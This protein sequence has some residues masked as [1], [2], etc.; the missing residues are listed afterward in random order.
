MENH[1]MADRST[2]CR[3]YSGLIPTLMTIVLTVVSCV[4]TTPSTPAPRPTPTISESEA[5]EAQSDGLTAYEEEG[6]FICHFEQDDI[7]IWQG[8]TQATETIV[9]EGETPPEGYLNVSG[10]HAKYTDRWIKPA[11]GFVL[12]EDQVKLGATSGKW[13]NTTENTRI[14]TTDIPHDWSE[15][16]FLSFW[17]YSAVENDAAIEIVAYSESEDTAEDDYYKKEI[18]IDW[19]GW[20]LFEIPLHEFGVVR[21]PVGWDKIDYIKIAATGWGHDPN[22][23]TELYFDGMK[24]SNQ[25]V[26]PLMAIELPQDLTHPYLLLNEAEIVEIKDKIEKHPW[27]RE[28]YVSLAANAD[29][30]AS[31]SIQLPDTGGGFYHAEDPTDYAITQEHYDH[32]NA[33]RDLALM[34]HLTGDEKYGQKAKEILMAYVD[35][36]LTYEI[37]DKEGRTGEQA[38]AGGRATPQAINETAW[39]VP[40]AWAYDL[41]YNDLAP[42]ERESIENKILRPAAELIM[43]N[44]EGRHNHQTWHNSGVG[45]VGFVLGDKELVWHALYKDDSGYFYQMEKSITEDGMWYEGSMHYQFYVLRA[46]FPLM[47]AAY[48][49]GIDLYQEPG[50]KGLFDFM[51][52]YADASMRLPTLH[53]G[54]VV[55]LPESDRA[56]YYEVAYRRLGDPRYIPVLQASTR[57]DRYALLYGVS[58]LPEPEWP[59]WESRSFASSHLAVLRSGYGMHSKQVVVNYMGYEGGHSHPDQ[60]GLVLYGLGL[61]LAPDAG[62]VKYRVPAHLEWFK[63]SIAH[64]VIVVDG[65]SQ[66]QASPG[67]LESFVGTPNLQVARVSSEEAYLGV[68]LERT[69]ILNDDYLIDIFQAD[70]ADEHTYD[71]V[72]HNIGRFTTDDLEFQPASAPGDENGYEYL[73]DV[74]SVQSDGD[75]QA[76]WIVAPDRRVRMGLFGAPGAEYF[77]ARGLIAAET[78]DEIAD[79]KVPL[80]IARRHITSTKFVSII[81]PYSDVPPITEMSTA[82]FTGV[83]GEVLSPDEAISLHIERGALTDVILIADAAGQ[84][85]YD[86]Y[87]FDGRMGWICFEGDDLEW[88]YLGMGTTFAGDGWSLLVESMAAASSAE[89]LGVYLQPTDDDRVYLQ[90]GSTRAMVAQ[91]DGLLEGSPKVFKLGRDG[92][93]TVEVDP[94]F[95][96]DGSV[97]FFVDPLAVYEIVGE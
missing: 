75:W 92:Y 14:V 5:E 57:T 29:S 81:Q 70:S 47:E 31:R 69:V 65:R 56:T 88:V 40:L 9:K 62:S 22:P 16:S 43:L 27:T 49:S 78:D 2:C 52:E 50:Y 42:E 19:E 33:A 4:T 36:Y 13:S 91:V 48:H 67:V 74:A 25:R 39:V 66:E 46:L 15:H 93:S 51:V 8:Y 44:N 37:H 90:S 87:V 6:V 54:R 82:E 45:V 20:R 53:D 17:A 95:S 21:S 1:R 94:I 76:K 28:A 83:G 71:W 41:I 77:A 68:R 10:W 85:Q 89:E 34:Y 97:R 26:A 58:E 86:E 35:T 61:T 63:Q 23:T 7:S 72:Y 32:A 38:S 80:L 11:D 59:E 60:L 79:Y 73:E 64:N 84:R 30:W 24:L 3:Y 12:N 18:V 96:K 55:H